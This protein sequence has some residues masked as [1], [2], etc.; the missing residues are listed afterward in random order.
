VIKASRKLQ[1]IVLGCGPAGLFATHAAIRAGHTVAIF[2]KKRK[3]HMYG[4]Q[5]LH[6]P[7]PDLTDDSPPFQVTYSL[8]GTV[9]EYAA[10][11]YGEVPPDFVS[12]QNLLGQHKAWDIRR[13]YDRAW[14]MYESLIVDWNVTSRDLLDWS[15][16]NRDVVINTIPLTEICQRPDA[17]FFKARKAWAIG[18]APDRDQFAPALAASNSVL[19]NGT[20]EGS[21]YR[22]SNI[23]GYQT[24]EWPEDNKP[25]LEG[26]AEVTKAV[27]TNCDCW[28][29]CAQPQFWRAG[30]YGTWM[31]GQFSHN[32]FYNMTQALTLAV[33]R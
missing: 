8:L 30:R 13:A 14:S 26:V 27:G 25:P 20:D 3:S 29:I 10:K 19:C 5:Y 1:I 23:L 33:V 9:E 2:S 24:V 7:I 21:W 31:K 17:H 12:P 28:R 6:A 4:A 11:V 22:A 15:M 18:D 16:S 32:A